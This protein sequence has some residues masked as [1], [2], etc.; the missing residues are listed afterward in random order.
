LEGFSTIVNSILTL[1]LAMLVGFVCVK[2]G[3]ITEEQ[4]NALSKIIV[5]VTLPILVVTSLTKL[6]LNHE[7]IVNCVYVLILALIIIGVMYAVGQLVSKLFHMDKKRAVMHS[8]M[9]CF[10]NVVF[11]AYPLIQALYGEEGLLYAAIFALANDLYLWTMGV[12]KMASTESGETSI[13]KNLKNLINPATIGFVISF[14]MMITG[15]KFTGV[16]KDVLTGIGG[17]TTYLSMLF[18]GGTLA[19]VDFRH[20]YKRVS[21][22]VLVAIKMIALPIC[23]IAILKLFNIS[24]I[25]KYVVILQ[26]AIPSSTVLTILATEYNTD[27][28]YSAEGVFITTIASLFTLPIVYYLMML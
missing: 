24:D 10:G 20:I 25:V 8:C 22:F 27:V 17:T 21:L 12:Y 1:G 28:I 6:E 11:M 4:K 5:K 9:S 23:L 13:K 7:K 18:I 15:L 3:Y 16:I 2:T 19:L 14:F 26:A